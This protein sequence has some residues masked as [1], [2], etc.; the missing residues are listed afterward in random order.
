[1]ELI[2]VLKRLFPDSVVIAIS[3]KGREELSR[4]KFAGA[5]ATLAKPVEPEEILAVVEKVIAQGPE[6][7]PAAED[8]PPEITEP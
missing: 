3:G 4:A 7:D 5:A 2:S 1:M 8:G 6:I